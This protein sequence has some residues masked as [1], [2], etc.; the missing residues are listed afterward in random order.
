VVER[1]RHRP[2]WKKISHLA[3]H[4]IFSSRAPSLAARRGSVEQGRAGWCRIVTGVGACTEHHAEGVVGRMPSIA[5]G[6]EDLLR[7]GGGVIGQQ[8]ERLLSPK[9]RMG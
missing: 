1:P 9:H 5:L 4:P 6:G 7:S 8:L 3:V 2:R